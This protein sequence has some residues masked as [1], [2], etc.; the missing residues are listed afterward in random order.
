MKNIH[1]RTFVTVKCSSGS[2]IA[3]NENPTGYQLSLVK[4]SASEECKPFVATAPHM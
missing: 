1:M 2:A 4:D 3:V